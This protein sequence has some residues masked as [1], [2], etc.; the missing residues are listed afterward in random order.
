MNQ[1]YVTGTLY[2][3]MEWISRIVYVNALWLLFTLMGGVI[4]GISPATAALF[5]ITKKWVNG[6]E[7]PAVF[8]QFWQEYRF[9]FWRSQKI[10]F[11]FG[12]AGILLFIDWHFFSQRQSNMNL[13]GKMLTVQLIL[14][15][16][17]L[18]FYIFPVFV[19]GEYKMSRAL[20]QAGFLALQAPFKTIFGLGSAAALLL[21]FITIPAVA[22]LC[23]ASSLAMWVWFYTERVIADKTGPIAGKIK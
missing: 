5:S 2:T 4:F 21:L 18:L 6:E 15:Y 20:K 10:S 7:V 1:G 12:V 9:Y 23:A 3:G 17:A 13:I 22:L 8:T 11:V 19:N 14:L 16:A